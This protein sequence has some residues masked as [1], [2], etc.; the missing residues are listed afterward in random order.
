MA[1]RNNINAAPKSPE[2]LAAEKA[3]F[4]AGT[5]ADAGVQSSVDKAAETQINKPTGETVTMSADQFQQIFARLNE[6]ESQKLN[7]VKREA[8]IFNP[9]AEVKGNYLVRIAFHNDKL[10]VGYKHRTRPDG[11]EISTYMKKDPETGQF[12]TTATLILADGF[13]KDGTLKTVEEEV[14]F[15]L[16]MQ[17][18]TSMQTT[19]LER[20]DV[21]KLLEQELT[22]QLIWNGRTMAPTGIQIRTGAKEQKWIFTVE[23]DGNRYSLPEEVINIL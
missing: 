3:I 1:K 9:L 16:F 22:S 2:D 17:S 12:R 13:E 18:L 21:G 11:K 23:H 5:G 14:D 19:C 7:E 4:G 15:V 10:V 20:K 6:L 8:D